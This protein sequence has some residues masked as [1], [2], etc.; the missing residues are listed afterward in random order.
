MSYV[1]WR[2]VTL[3][4]VEARLSS[5]LRGEKIEQ[6][7]ETKYTQVHYKGVDEAMTLIGLII[8]KKLIE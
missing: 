3:G 2:L 5:K 8:N 7:G 6:I 4:A 1:K